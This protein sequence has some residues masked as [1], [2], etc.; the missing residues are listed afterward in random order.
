MVKRFVPGYHRGL[1]SK[2][3]DN[4]A[5]RR[6]WVSVLCLSALIYYPPGYSATC[7]SWRKVGA[8]PGGQEVKPG[9]PQVPS[10]VVRP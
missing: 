10:P 5:L 4:P 2:A 9:A 3:D 8:S 7:G 6:G 1:F